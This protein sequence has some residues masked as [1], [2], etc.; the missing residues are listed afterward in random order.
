MH[1]QLSGPHRRPDVKHVT[2]EGR[3]VMRIGRAAVAL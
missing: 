1:P 3:V 2:S